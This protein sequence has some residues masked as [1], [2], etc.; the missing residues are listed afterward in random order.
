M[1]INPWQTFWWFTALL[2]ALAIAL[3]NQ[4]VVSW[5]LEHFS[6]PVTLTVSS[7]M[8]LVQGGRLLLVAWRASFS[9]LG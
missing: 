7:A 6:S 1:S 2:A 9:R 3:V 4:G 8:L 5:F